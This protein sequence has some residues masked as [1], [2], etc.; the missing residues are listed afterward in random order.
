VSKV[1]FVPNNAGFREFL[2]SEPVRAMVLN[3]AEA[4]ADRAGGNCSVQPLLLSRQIAIVEPADEKT[5]RDNLK[6]NTLLKAIGAKL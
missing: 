2:R 4:V 1:K 5:R 6:N 3:R